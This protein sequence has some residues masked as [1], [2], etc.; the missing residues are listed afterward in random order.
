MHKQLRYYINDRYN[1]NNDIITNS[2]SCVSIS[3]LRNIFQRNSIEFLLNNDNETTLKNYDSIKSDVTNIIKNFADKNGTIRDLIYRMNAIS[4]IERE[5]RNRAFKTYMLDNNFSNYNNAN[6]IIGCDETNNDNIM[7]HE[8]EAI[9]MFLLSGSDNKVTLQF[10]ID[11][12]YNFLYD[13]YQLKNA[14]IQN[15]IYKITEPNIRYLLMRSLSNNDTFP[16][17]SLYDSDSIFDNIHNKKD[18]TFGFLIYNDKIKK[19]LSYTIMKLYC[20]NE[21]FIETINYNLVRLPTIPY[22]LIERIRKDVVFSEQFRKLLYNLFIVYYQLLLFNFMK[23]TISF[24]NTLEKKSVDEID[25]FINKINNAIDR[26]LFQDRKFHGYLL[27]LNEK[28][29]NKE[30][31]KLFDKY[32]KEYVCNERRK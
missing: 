1:D 11:S 20:N 5:Y 15:E 27:Y 28:Y 16:Y 9:V 13:F 30:L 23:Y 22:H 6:K 29:D 12:I 7:N 17:N 3:N 21:L 24:S 14:K 8:I 2:S 32:L 4:P 10:D 25:Y 31:F 18:G 26:K 19:S